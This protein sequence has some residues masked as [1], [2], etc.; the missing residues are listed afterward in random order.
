MVGYKKDTELLECV[1]R[2]AA[3]VMKD[4][5]GRRYESL[6]LFNPEKRLTGGLIVVYDFFTK[7]K[8]G[9]GTDL[10]SLVTTTGPKRMAWSCNR[11]DSG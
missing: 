9:A 4:L 3:Y 6:D 8:G 1:Q 2:M 10:F 5:E 11:V 7:R